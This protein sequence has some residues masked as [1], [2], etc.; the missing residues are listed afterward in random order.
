MQVSEVFSSKSI[1]VGHRITLEGIFVMSCGIGCFVQNMDD[2]GDKEK[3][4]FIEHPDL[5]N[6][7]LSC[8]P[9]FGGGKISYCDKAKISGVLN[10]EFSEGF[11][12]K[13]NGVSDFIIFRNDA[14]FNVKL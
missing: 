9:A 3:S 11:L 14:V 1:P 2:L 5:E 10:R 13:F 8:V 7:L 12:C 4:I 6:K